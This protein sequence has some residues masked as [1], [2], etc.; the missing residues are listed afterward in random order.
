[1]AHILAYVIYK[2]A[3]TTKGHFERCF[4]CAARSLGIQFLNREITEKTKVRGRRCRQNKNAERTEN[5]FKIKV[6]KLKVIRIN[7]FKVFANNN[8]LSKVN[9][10]ETVC[11]SWT[12]ICHKLFYC[13]YCRY[14]LTTGNF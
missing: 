13:K 14:K 3:A 6:K 8:N 2:M 1:M 7:I 10:I 11:W 4:G 5:V 12:V 9:N